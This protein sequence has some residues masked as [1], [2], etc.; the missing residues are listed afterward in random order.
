MNLVPD[1][2]LR[3]ALSNRLSDWK[4]QGTSLQRTFQFPSFRA[5]MDFVNQIAGAAEEMN[6]H[7]DIDVRYDKVTLALSSHDAGGITQRD[8]ALAGRANEIAS[9]LARS[10]RL[11]TA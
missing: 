6:H 1:I 9:N 2:E 5:A 3:N 11:K 7:P 4:V 10:N 8:M